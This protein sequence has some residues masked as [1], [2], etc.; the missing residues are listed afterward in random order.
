MSLRARKKEETRQRLA[1][2]ATRLFFQRGFDAVTV[3]E[4]A[5]AADVSKMTLFNYFPRKEDLFLD[6]H[7]DVLDDVRRVAR[8][9]PA[10]AAFRRYCHQ[11]L[12]ARHPFSGAVEGVEAFWSVLMGS[13][14]LRTRRLQQERELEE[15]LAEELGDPLVAALIAATLRAVYMAAISDRL[16]GASAEEVAARQ[17][18]VIDRAFDMLEHGLPT[19]RG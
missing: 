12:A 8:S 15:A 2:V 3:A 7:A 11:L 17:P 6:R 1:D 18:A 10:V 13:E 9:G 19:R 14:A 4:I 16:A 5:E